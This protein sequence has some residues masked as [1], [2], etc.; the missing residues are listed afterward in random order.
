MTALA[1]DERGRLWIGALGDLFRFENE[2]LVKIPELDR[3]TVWAIY[4]DSRGDAWIGT[5]KGLFQ[6]RDDKFVARYTTGDGLPSNDVKVIHESRD[7]TL[8]LGTYGR[9]AKLSEPLA[10]AGGLTEPMRND[11]LTEAT[12]KTK[13][14]NRLTL[15]ARYRRRF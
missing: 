13:R 2:R 12:Q 3:T 5:E 15:T 6:F 1:E 9:L 11:V 14:L 8:W 10:V 4:F 7:E